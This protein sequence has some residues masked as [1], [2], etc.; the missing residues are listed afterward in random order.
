M[1]TTINL[2]ITTQSSKET[3]VGHTVL[4]RLGLILLPFCYLLWTESIVKDWFL[5]TADL[6]PY[7][8]AG[9][10]TAAAFAGLA[11]LLIARD[12]YKVWLGLL[13]F[14]DLLMVVGLLLHGGPSVG[15]WATLPTAL[16]VAG[17]WHGKVR[18]IAWPLVALGVFA[19]LICALPLSLRL[20]LLLAP[21]LTALCLLTQRAPCELRWSL[22]CCLTFGLIVLVALSVL[23][24]PLHLLQTDPFG[25]GLG[26]FQT[27]SFARTYLM[28]QG[29]IATISLA[30]LLI[31][32][33]LVAFQ[34]ALLSTSQA[35]SYETLLAA[36]ASGTLLTLLL[37]NAIRPA[38][39]TDASA[40]GTWPL[41][42]SLALPGLTHFPKPEP[43]AETL[44]GLRARRRRLL[45]AAALPC[46]LCLMWL[47]AFLYHA[48]HLILPYRGNGKPAGYS[49]YVPL[50]HIS[51]T[52]QD[53]TIATEDGS[54]YENAGVDWNATDR[55][56]R[57]DIRAG[58]IKLGG[59]TITQQLARN[60]FLTPRKTLSRKLE[61]ILIA[62]LMNRLL[63]KKR[64]LELYLN[65]IDYGLGYHGI[66]QAAW[67][68]FYTTP[69]KLT[70][71]QSALLAG[72]VSHPPKPDPQ[73][74]ATGEAQYVPLDKMAHWQQTALGRLSAFFGD[75]Y[76][77]AQ[78]QQAAR[79]PIDRFVRPYRDV[80]DR[81]ATD[82]I[83]AHWL[84][85]SF[86]S[87]VNPQIPASIP[88]VAPCLKQHL[89]AF[90]LLAHKTLGLVGIHHLGVYNDRTIRNDLAHLSAHA[91]GQ[92]I[93]IAGFVF[94][95][96]TTMWVKD[97]DNPS[98]TPKLL[99]VEKLLKR[100]FDLVLDWQ[101]NPSEHQ[102]HFHCEV[103]GPR[104]PAPTPPPYMFHNSIPNSA[105]GF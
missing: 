10:I 77:T 71:A 26:T 65:T 87:F 82:F 8:L 66:A 37:F 40:L 39:L 57:I 2:D 98:V 50:N 68:Y 93:D 92:A 48:Y 17:L 100:H 104:P 14:L 44:T 95:N 86:Y 36:S 70:L 4:R 9:Y 90:L 29:P 16:A 61:E 105:A 52:M 103:R 22:F 91:Y 34:R 51:Q 31:V 97:H 79:I 78:L 15:L 94:S 35:H 96:R 67:G 7:R 1:P 83:P 72:L 20:L 13:G 19:I 56:M 58:E 102:T 60:L 75:R 81:G 46:D 12:L 27:S 41:A 11:L 76:T 6:Y 64:I 55:A 54:F 5:S 33:G 62:L 73:L 45:V 59:S 85:V 32:A 53:A 21:A 101:N 18:K 88:N 89:A 49:V 74:A 47:A 28:E 42:L 69:D 80:Y 24:H 63:P 38:F 25:T 99:K 84:G 3:S 23:P 43:S 30:L